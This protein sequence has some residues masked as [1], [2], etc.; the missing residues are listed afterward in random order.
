VTDPDLVG[1]KLARIESSV[2]ELRELARPE[3]LRDDIF[4]RRFVERTLQIAI[5][6][7][8]DIAAH[9][10]ADDWL[11]EPRNAR[12][13]FGLLAR[14]NVIDRSLAARLESMVGFRNIVVHEY[15]DIDLDKVRQILAN[16][17]DDLLIFAAA[18]RARL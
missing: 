7:A 12:D 3:L 17:L 16:D 8:M 9:V 2:D 13:M 4:H 15:D 6:A 10:I 18:M 14:K 11:G 1:K 5:Q